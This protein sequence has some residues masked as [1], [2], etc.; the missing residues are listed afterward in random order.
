MKKTDS[1]DDAAVKTLEPTEFSLD[2]RDN[3]VGK[4]SCISL[5]LDSQRAV[6]QTR[7][8]LDRYILRSLSKLI[9]QGGGGGEHSTA[10]AIRD[11]T[12][13]SIQTFGVKLQE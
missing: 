6:E 2:W 11:M 12:H 13:Y 1:V 10:T 3:R 7:N 9:V 4:T 5:S 8:L